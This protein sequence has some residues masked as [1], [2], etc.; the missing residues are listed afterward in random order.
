MEIKDEYLIGVLRE[1]V[2]Q[3]AGRRMSSPKDFDVLHQM[4]L[5]AHTPLGISTLMRIWGYVQRDGGL[6]QTSLTTLAQFVG[7]ADWEDFCRHQRDVAD[8]PL[9]SDSR[10]VRRTTWP[11]V[12][13]ALSGMVITI[14]A[15]LLLSRQDT[16]ST[17][18]AEQPVDRVL[19]KGQDCFA[20]I[21]DYLSLFNIH[22][23]DTAYYQP[24]PGL[25]EVYVWGPE[26][27]NTTWHNEGDK[28][29][30]MPTIAEYWTPSDSIHDADYVQLANEKLYYER[31]E[32]D[33]LRL[34]FMRNIV[35]TLYVFIG[36]YRMDR[37]LST[38]ERCV[39]RRVADS[40]DLGRLSE[41]Q[42]PRQR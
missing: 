28:Q 38:K 30:L 20:T 36:V 39:W 9:P 24:L 27:G 1:K 10:Q 19:H 14:L 41:L 31:L 25:H 15:V 3:K 29:Q 8:Q 12:A 4:L 22:A 26:Y 11:W 23:T 40:V 16:N 17:N 42:L 21:D 37:E 13:A 33:E 7:Y 34:T 35:D 2:E 32:R 6:R 5:D 18:A